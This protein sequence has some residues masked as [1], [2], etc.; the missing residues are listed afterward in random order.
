MIDDEDDG[1]DD[2]G[3]IDRMPIGRG[4]RSA[5]MSVCPPQLPHDMAWARTRAAAVGSR[6]TNRLSYGTAL[7]QLYCIGRIRNSPIRVLVVNLLLLFTII[8]QVLSLLM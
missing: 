4:N 7:S 5:P 3:S 6:P 2:C 1:D 8:S